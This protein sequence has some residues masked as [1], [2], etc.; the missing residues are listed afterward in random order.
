MR[1]ILFLAVA[2]ALLALNWQAVVAAQ[3]KKASP[4]KKAATSPAPKAATTAT[5]KSA[6]PAQKSAS[7]ARK[8]ATT[9]SA[10]RGKK[11]PPVKATWRNRQTVPSQDRFKEIQDALAAKGYLKPEQAGGAWDTAS[12][13]AMKR[14]QADQKLEAS[15]KINS[16]SLIALGLGPKREAA[17]V[18]PPTEPAVVDR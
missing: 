8:T 1:R 5:R 12:A 14:F 2:A 11:A 7:T 4:P 17:A 15:G 6:A 16:L 10:K 18:K 13:D 9:A 3:T